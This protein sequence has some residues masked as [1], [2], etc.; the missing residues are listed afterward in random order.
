MNNQ[1][2]M[3]HYLKKIAFLI[4]GTVIFFGLSLSNPAQAQEQIELSIFGPALPQDLF[5]EEPAS[6]E[7]IDLG[8]MLLYYKYNIK[9][10]KTNFIK[11]NKLISHIQH[12]K[13]YYNHVVYKYLVI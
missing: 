5:L 7:L 4:I 11:E 1:L 9:N 8:R 10:E 12:F 13:I 3:T 2:S 6:P